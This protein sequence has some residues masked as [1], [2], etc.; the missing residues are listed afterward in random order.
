MDSVWLKLF[1]KTVDFGGV[2]LPKFKRV[3]Q[4]QCHFFRLKLIRV[5]IPEKNVERLEV[6][7]AI[8][9]S[10]PKARPA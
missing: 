3:F 2:Y 10:L 1:K 9:N 5:S 8:G 4:N 7:Q 6:S